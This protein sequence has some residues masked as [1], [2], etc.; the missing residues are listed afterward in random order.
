MR[1]KEQLNKLNYFCAIVEAG[2]I[3]N[4][5][6]LV[7]VG[8]PQLTKTLK[9]LE[10]TLDCSLMV[11]SSRG[12]TL[13]KSGSQ[14]YSYAKN[15]LERTDEIEFLIQS[16]LDHKIEGKIRIGTYDS[17]SRYFFP[18]F[19]KYLRAVAPDLQV[20]LETGR[21][22]AMISKLEAGGL[23]TVVIVDQGV[24]IEGVQ[25]ERIYTDSFGLYSSPNLDTDF[26]DSLIYFSF[27]INETER[28]ME[29]FGFVQSILCD[30]LETVRSMTEQA[31]G[32][33]L[34]PHRVARES[35]LSKKLTLFH[36]PKIKKNNFDQHDI[37][38]CYKKLANNEGRDFV[39]GEIRRFLDVWSRK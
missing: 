31:V 12:I 1:L 28:S 16:G 10:D 2:S 11:R 6:K 29:K 38:M 24:V 20:Y 25:S 37:I 8:Q 14:L 13:T 26:Y 18:Q 9:Q 27:P 34:L 17:I 4:A 35:V 36:H 15:V 39:V 19:L 5:S 7:F 30:N 22:R 32:V 23:D 3:K 21:S 33:G